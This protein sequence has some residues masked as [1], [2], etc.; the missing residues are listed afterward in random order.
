MS[1]DI[2]AKLSRYGKDD[3][4]KYSMEQGKTLF[5]ESITLP[6]G[7][8]IPNRLAKAPMGEERADAQGRPNRSLIEMYRSWAHGGFGLSITGNFMVDRSALVA[9]GNVICETD[10]DLDGLKLWASA[11]QEN[12]A[13]CWVQICHAGRQTSSENPVAPSA[14]GLP[15]GPP[16]RA[17]EESEIL[18]IIQQF[19]ATA[20]ICKDAGFKGV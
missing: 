18:D 5:L 10:R 14:V 7:V 8:V 3:T 1:T 16:P 6:C 2:A 20:K 11:A 13:H 15:W 9:P 17:L 19:V 4:D 12:G